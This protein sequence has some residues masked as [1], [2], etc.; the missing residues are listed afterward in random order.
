VSRTGLRSGLDAKF[1]FKS[2]TFRFRREYFFGKRRGAAGPDSSDAEK[3][4][5]GVGTRQPALHN[6][7]FAR[8]PVFAGFCRFSQNK[9]KVSS[10]KFKV[11]AWDERRRG[12]RLLDNGP[13]L[14]PFF[15]LII[16][17]SRT[18]RIVYERIA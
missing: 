4:E 13:G 17:D 14:A 7:R 5:Q 11:E 18:L 8:V 1:R 10:L 6:R 15:W 3:W 16:E 9:F 2:G 12:T